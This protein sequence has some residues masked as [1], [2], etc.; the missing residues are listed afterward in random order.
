MLIQ[1]LNQA[2]DCSDLLP[3]HRWKAVEA[4]RAQIEVNGDGRAT[5]MDV[6]RS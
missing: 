3:S 4:A 2:E 1:C 5:A 6:I